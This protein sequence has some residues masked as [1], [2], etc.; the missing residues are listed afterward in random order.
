[1]TGMRKQLARL[2]VYPS[3]FLGIGLL[4]VGTFTV[5]HIVD[6]WW[7]FEVE[8]LDL[9]RA[10]ALHTIEAAVLLDAANMQIILAFLA[11]ALVA[12]TGLALPLAY[13]LNRRFGNGGGGAANGATPRFLVLVRQSMWVGLWVAFCLWLQMNRA[14]GFAV[15]ALVAAVLAMFEL[16]LQV[17]TR[18]KDMSNVESGEVVK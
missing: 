13:V 10:T 12:A 14:L 17:R 11:S 6:N 9:V 15:A 7:P 3:L 8:R 1:M 5:N 16:L 18:A 4:L 2:G